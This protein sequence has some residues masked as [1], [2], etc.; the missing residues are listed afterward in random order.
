MTY[1]PEPHWS[2]VA[3][4]IRRRGSKNF[5]AGD[6]NPYYRY[7]RRK[8]LRH[9]LRS[10][11]VRSKTVLEVGC[12][13]GGNLLELASR[14]PARLIGVD[15]SQAMINLAVENLS[16]REQLVELRKT[17]G[18][19]IPLPDLSV[20]ITLTVTVLQHNTVP[21]MF[22]GLVKEICRVTKTAILL[23]EDTGTETDPVPA[24]R[25]AVARPV[26]AYQAECCKHG[27]R[28]SACENLGLRVSRRLHGGVRRC[29]GPRV[30]NVGEP[31]P[32]LA[33]IAMTVCLPVTRVL[34]SVCPDDRDLTKMAFVRDAATADR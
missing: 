25:S 14:R 34:D 19:T 22:Q 13:P 2:R 8:F 9:L 3:E 1:H 23:I 15:I 12:G 29:L 5:L 28:L 21:A 7:K 32:T 27:F 20:D 30:R 11:D 16:G 33:K 17:D 24:S 18:T 6:D 26:G 31:C 10:I 4:H